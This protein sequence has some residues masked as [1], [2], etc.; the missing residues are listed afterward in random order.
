MLGISL[1]RKKSKKNSL[2]LSFI[3]FLWMKKV[4]PKLSEVFYSSINQ[5]DLYEFY[6][7]SEL[8]DSAIH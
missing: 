1:R 6:R 7:R 3:T 5:E 8:K 2:V 4:L